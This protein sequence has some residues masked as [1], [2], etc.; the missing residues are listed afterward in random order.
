MS[1]PPPEDT[2]LPP[3]VRR[4]LGIEGRRLDA[5]F[6]LVLLAFVGTLLVMTLDYGRQTRLVP[7]VIGVPTFAML[8]ALLAMQLSPRLAAVAG[9][10]AAGGL[11]EDFADR[12][13]ELELEDAEADEAPPADPVSGRY[14]LALVLGWVLV[15][16]L[17]VVVIGFLAGSFV[18]LLGFYRLRAKQDWLRTVAYTVVVWVFAVVIF[19]AVLNTPLYEGLLGVEIPLPV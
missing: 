12:I 15:L 19:K 17:L 10:Y 5:A 14:E 2:G 9:R 8:A 3:L 6:T 13:D 4:L 7:L 18:Y 16:F 11:F 1:G